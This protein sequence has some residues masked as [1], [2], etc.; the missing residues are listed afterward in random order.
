MDWIDDTERSLIKKFFGVDPL[1]F[2]DKG[3]LLGTSDF[4]T[5]IEFYKFEYKDREKAFWDVL[6]PKLLRKPNIDMVLRMSHIKRLPF[7]WVDY[8]TS[9]NIDFEVVEGYLHIKIEEDSNPYKQALILI[10]NM[11]FVSDFNS[12]DSS[13]E[14]INTTQAWKLILTEAN[15]YE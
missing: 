1:D 15:N 11:L 4:Y 5:I 13:Y 3:L 10:C 9:V 14:N 12:I 8:V 2:L 6:Y 7:K